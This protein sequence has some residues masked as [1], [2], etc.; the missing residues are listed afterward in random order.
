MAESTPRQRCQSALRCERSDPPPYMPAVYEHKAWF[1]ENTPSRVSR[2]ADLFFRAMMTEY[3]RLQPDALVVGMDVY[4]IEA[5]AAGCR[6]TFYEGDD[7]SVPGIAPNDHVVGLDDDLASLPIPDPA[8]AGRMP[9]NIEVAR[10]VVRELGDTVWI[11]GAISG[12]FSLAVSLMGSESLFLATIDNPDFVRRLLDYA[13]RIIKGFGQAYI[14]VGADVILF[15]SQASPELLPPTTFETLILPVLCEVIDYFHSLAVRDVPL[16]IGGNT[17]AISDACI[18]TGANNLLCDFRADWP[19]WL[20]KCR[21]AG[22]AVRRNL[23]PAFLQRATPDDIY[24][25]TKRLIAEADGYPGFIIGTA[26]VPYGTPTENLMAVRR[27]C[28]DRS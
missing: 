11:R 19:T 8:I 27:A 5:E 10:Q 25:A 24:D 2:D 22:R 7:A 9:L 12:P 20:D 26:V 6:V 16:I 18:A 15:D 28:H 17:T 13:G 1:L 4:N 21:T 23:D 14:D 3:E